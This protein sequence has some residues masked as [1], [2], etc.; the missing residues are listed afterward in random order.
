MEEGIE[1][2]KEEI[3]RQATESSIEAY[4]VLADFTRHRDEIVEE[5]LSMEEFEF[6]VYE[7]VNEFKVSK[8]YKKERLA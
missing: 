5:F 2:Q 7:A 4:L 1:S 8:K 6:K 3:R